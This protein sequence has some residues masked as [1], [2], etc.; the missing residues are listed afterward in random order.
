MIALFLGE[1]AMAEEKIGFKPVSFAGI[2]GWA[3][4][5]HAAAFRALL[6]SCRKMAKRNAACKAALKLGDKT[7]RTA[8]RKFF[9][10]HYVPHEVAG[11]PQGFVTGYYEPEVRGARK[12]SETFHVPVYRKP[13]DLVTLKPDVARARFNDQI[14][15]MRKT[16]GGLVPYYARAEIDGGALAGRG[17]ELLYLEDPVELFFLQ[18]QGSGRVRLADGSVLRLGFAAKN[19]HPYTSIGKRLVEM[20][21]GA[22]DDMT[23]DGVKAWL[24]ADPA[25]GRTLMHENRSYVFFREIAGDGPVGAQ[26]VALTPGRSLAVDTEYHRLGLPVFVTAPD[27]ATPDGTPYRRL[28]I[29]QDAGSAIRGPERGDIFWGSGEAAGAIA[30]HTRHAA[31]FH[32]LLPK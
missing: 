31:K 4:D 28:M 3:N 5:D 22:P 32:V 24:R 1:S 11:S 7:G 29:A 30:G 18:V 23:M 17:L 20:G 10:T 26:G 9:E 21:E 6:K 8:A 15:G 16:P 19:G 12:R 13:R 14:T 25:R 27:L 2:D